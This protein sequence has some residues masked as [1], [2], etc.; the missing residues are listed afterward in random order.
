MEKQERGMRRGLLARLAAPFRRL[1]WRMTFSYTVVTVSAL[2]LLEFL[3]IAGGLFAIDR[4]FHSPL[5]ARTVDETYAPTLTR[6]LRPELRKRS[7]NLAAL[8]STLDLYGEEPPINAGD[9][10]MLPSD[11]LFV[12]NSE[13]LVLAT[14][15]SR[16]LD[17]RQK[18]YTSLSVEALHPLV[19][20][21]LDEAPLAQRYTF[22]DDHILLAS[23]IVEEESGEIL[24]A[25]GYISPIPTVDWRLVRTLLPAVGFSLAFFTLGVGVIGTLFGFLTSRPLV[26]RLAQ[27]STV[28]GDWSRGDFTAFVQDEGGDEIAALGRR[29]NRMA[30]QLQNLLEERNRLAVVEERN[31]IARDL[32]DSAKQQAFAAAGQIGAAQALLSRDPAAAA[33]HLREAEELVYSLRQELSLLIEELRPAALE[34]KGLGTALQEYV[35]RWSRR[36]GITGEV[37]LRGSANLSLEMEQTLFRIA[38]EALANVARH[39]EAGRVHL[40]LR[41]DGGG[42]R[43]RVVDDGTG[44]EPQRVTTGF[45]L[46][47]IRQRAASLPGGSF[48]LESEPGAGTTIEVRAEIGDPEREE[49]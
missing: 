46:N 41:Y 11:E 18:P 10:G 25:V 17:A 22:V 6:T 34:E 24:G 47:S 31:R 13:G 7:P 2:V 19:E 42:I 12:V 38:Q 28:A 15:G 26:R 44:F 29:M 39:S 1:Q 35:E 21:A 9:N 43:L 36:S 27:L 33:E 8:Q 40:A 3:I 16:F 30:E 48:S 37:E 23:P 4:F 32:H 5:M 45:G 49:A 14:S 20:A